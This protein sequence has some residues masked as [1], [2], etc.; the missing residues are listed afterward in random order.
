MSLSVVILAAGLGTRMK[1]ALPKMLHPVAGRPMVLYGVE[2]ARSLGAEAVVLI[3]GHGAEQVRAAVGDGVVYALQPEPL[4]TGHAVMQAEPLLRGRGGTVLVYYGD[5]P[6]LQAET[7]RQLAATHEETRATLTLLTLIADDPMGFGRIVRDSAGR[8]VGIVEESVATPE[9]KRIREL[10]CGVYAFQAD[11]LWENVHRLQKSPKGEFFLTDLVEMAVA[12]G[13]RVEAVATEDAEQMLGIN[14]RTH[15]ARAEAVVRKRV[16]ERLM[17]GGVTLQDPASTYVDADVQVG[18]DTVI[19][20]NTHLQGRTRI[21]ARCRIGPN[22]IVRDSAIGDDCKVEAS[23]VEEAVLE[24]RVDIGPF[25]H[26]RKGAHLARGVHMGNFGEVKNS[27]L[28]P[29][30]KMGHFSYL[31]DAE[32]GADVN[33]GAGTITCNFDGERKHKTVIEDGA[34]IGSDTMLVAPVRIGKGAK[35]GAGS[36]VTHD[37]PP[38]A[39]AYGVPARVRKAPSDAAPPSEASGEQESES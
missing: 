13:R 3:V 37:V 9:Q 21:G 30:T 2:T 7:L 1:S 6:L 22:T 33:I 25:A 36:V 34:F 35:T 11:W 18:P 26:L 10:N 4:G 32:V 14:D 29:G 5:M 27:Y 38:G 31:G 39:V 23:V 24:D 8:V 12:Q 19:Y 20:A 16:A 28:G 17:L 15:L